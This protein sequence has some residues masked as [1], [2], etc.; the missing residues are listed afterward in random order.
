M[1]SDSS[2]IDSD[3]EDVAAVEDT[4]HLIPRRL[5]RVDLLQLVLRHVPRRL[6]RRVG[7]LDVEVPW[8]DEGVERGDATFHHT[9]VL[10]VLR[11][12]GERRTEGR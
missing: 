3:L 8:C 11:L 5:I 4:D 7:R 9:V 1:Y 12:S 10:P 6:Q 2:L